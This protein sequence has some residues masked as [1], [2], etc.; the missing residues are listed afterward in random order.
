VPRAFH[1]RS[2]AQRS[3]PEAPCSCHTIRSGVERDL[4]RAPHTLKCEVHKARVCLTEALRLD[5]RRDRAR[6]LDAIAALLKEASEHIQG[7]IG[8]LS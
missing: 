1:Y 2:C 5:R 8:E 6:H 7:A 4:L 3:D